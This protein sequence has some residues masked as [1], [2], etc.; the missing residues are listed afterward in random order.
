MVAFP[1]LRSPSLPSPQ[2]GV[3]TTP[4]HHHSPSYVSFLSTA[5]LL[6]PFHFFL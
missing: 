6:P 4:H 3:I 2:E 1:L 5:S